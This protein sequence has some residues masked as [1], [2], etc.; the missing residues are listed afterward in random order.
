[1]RFALGVG[2]ILV[3][4]RPMPG[5]G[6][7]PLQPPRHIDIDYRRGCAGL[8]PDDRVPRVEC[9]ADLYRIPAEGGEARLA[10]WPSDFAAGCLL[11]DG[12]DIA[13]I[14]DRSGSE[15]IWVI[16]GDGSNPRQ[17]TD[18]DEDSVFASPAWSADGKSISSPGIGPR[19]MASNLWRYR[20]PAARAS[21]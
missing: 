8:S 1:M 10:G 14:S 12:R 16:G 21:W 4:G 7:L 6:A 13:F 19:T 2:W 20:W 5:W 11:P 18:L 17:L 3:A 9:W 15:N